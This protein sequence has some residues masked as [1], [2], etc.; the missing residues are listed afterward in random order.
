MAV[1]CQPEGTS[2][3]IFKNRATY[4]FFQILSTSPTKWW[5]AVDS[6]SGVH[7]ACV[8]K[9]HQNCKLM[10]AALPSQID[11]KLLLEKMACD[12]PNNRNC[13]LRS[14]ENCLGIDELEKHL[15]FP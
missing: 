12:V 11:Y 2:F 7:S 15:K 5:I 4:W 6:S 9:I 3:G 8:C 14:C 1:T 10:A 13:I